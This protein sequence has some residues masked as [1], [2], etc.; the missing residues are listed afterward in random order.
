MAVDE[1]NLEERKVRAL[2]DI[3][4]SFRDLNVW[5]FE[6]YKSAWGTRV[7]WYLHEF[8]TIL[9]AKNLGS[10]SRPMRDS[11]RPNDERPQ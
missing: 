6:I 1:K 3:A 5:M 10:V 8:H 11:E 2:E 7:E 4:S 9:K